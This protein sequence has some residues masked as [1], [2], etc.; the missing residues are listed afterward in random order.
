MVRHH[1]QGTSAEDGARV[2]NI[3]L[4]RDGRRVHPEPHYRLMLS[5]PVRTAGD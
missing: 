5:G 2:L 4:D 3:R 1:Q